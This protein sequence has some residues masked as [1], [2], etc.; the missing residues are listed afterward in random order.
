VGV[1][2]V[3]LALM[4]LEFAL[5]SRI[6]MAAQAFGEDSLQLFHNL[7]GMVALLYLLAHPILLIVTGYPANCWLN[8]FAGCANAITRAA[9]LALCGLSLL[10][11]LS[12]WRKKLG[13]KY[14]LW[15]VTHGV[16]A[17]FV[18][19]AAMVHINA[20]GRYTSSPIMRAVWLA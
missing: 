18:L 19:I 14:E 12:V 9:A 7:M 1:G 16:F 6:K 2:F 20:I 13:I 11:G 10:V 17:L 3:G 8:P 5:I 4:C 15:Q